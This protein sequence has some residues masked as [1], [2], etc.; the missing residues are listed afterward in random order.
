MSLILL[1]RCQFK[2]VGFTDVDWIISSQRSKSFELTPAKRMGTPIINLEEAFDQNST[3]SNAI[4][5]RI[6]KEKNE[7]SG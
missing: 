3:T 4:S 1:N 7:K 6:K 2:I 5:V